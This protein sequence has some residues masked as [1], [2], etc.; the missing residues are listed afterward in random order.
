MELFSEHVCWSAFS[1]NTDPIPVDVLEL[2]FDAILNYGMPKFELTIPHQFARLFVFIFSQFFV[3]KVTRTEVHFHVF[4]RLGYLKSKVYSNN[5]QTIDE[6]KQ[7]IF[8]E[9]EIY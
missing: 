9:C 8:A 1:I 3:P 5:P 4:L 2:A 6:L 7:A